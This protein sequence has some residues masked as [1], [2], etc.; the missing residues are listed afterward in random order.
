MANSCKANWPLM[1]DEW[2]VA[3]E[4]ARPKL[5]KHLMLIL[6]GEVRT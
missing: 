4:C 3:A 1:S 5:N 2:R 6:Y